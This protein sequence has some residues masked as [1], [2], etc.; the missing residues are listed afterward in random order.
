MGD[1]IAGVINPF[2]LEVSQT[3]QHRI[4][5]DVLRAWLKVQASLQGK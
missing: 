3:E 4:V 1:W 5:H 2:A